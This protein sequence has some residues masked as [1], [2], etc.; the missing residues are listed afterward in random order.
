MPESP[1]RD[2]SATPINSTA[3][4]IS[5]TLPSKPNGLMERYRLYYSVMGSAYSNNCKVSGEGE[6]I[7]ANNSTLLLLTNL[8]KGTNYSL[9]LTAY[10]SVGAGPSSAAEDCVYSTALDSESHDCNGRT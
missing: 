4:T 2:C 3:L 7:T 9:S 1:P 5:W 8:K 6:V 10:T